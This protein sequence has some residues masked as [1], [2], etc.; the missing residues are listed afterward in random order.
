MIGGKP[1]SDS[2]SEDQH[3]VEFLDSAVGTDMEAND[4]GNME[5]LLAVI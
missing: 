2:D 3:Y 1:P 5:R 4:V